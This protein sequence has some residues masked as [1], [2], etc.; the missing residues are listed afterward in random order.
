M[1][2]SE[3]SRRSGVPIASI[4]YFLREGLLPAG[5]ATA[6]TLAEYGEAHIQRLR[7]IKALT[8]VGGLSIA[9]ARDVLAAVDGAE[10][11]ARTLQAISYALPVPVAAPAAGEAGADAEV[12]D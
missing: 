12:A 2:I 5:Q 7:L 9:A 3:L 11:P 6:A 1:K 10:S 4:K 8:T